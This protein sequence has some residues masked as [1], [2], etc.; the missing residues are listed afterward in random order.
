MT[1][2]TRRSVALGS[3]LIAALPASTLASQTKEDPA[4]GACRDYWKARREAHLADLEET[5]AFNRVEKAGGSLERADGVHVACGYPEAVQ[6]SRLTGNIEREAFKRALTTPPTTTVGLA[7][8]WSVL[9]QEIDI[10]DLD[11]FVGAGIETVSQILGE[12][13]PN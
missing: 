3:A 5:A 2:I 1:A 13:R 11:P 10:D 4:V 8:L 6:R 9:R 7:A 12:F